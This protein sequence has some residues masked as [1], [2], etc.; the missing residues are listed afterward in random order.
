M[1]G[2]RQDKADEEPSKDGGAWVKSSFDLTMEALK[3]NYNAKLY[4]L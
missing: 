2:G 4:P 1:E 3:I